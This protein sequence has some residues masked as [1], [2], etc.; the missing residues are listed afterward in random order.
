M[1]VLAGSGSLL[2]FHAEKDLPE[3]APEDE[4]LSPQRYDT[5]LAS[6]PPTSESAAIQL[7]SDLSAKYPDLRTHIVHLSAAD[8]LPILQ[9]AKNKGCLLT[10]ETC[11]H[12]LCLDSEDVSDGRCEFKCCPP[13][14]EAANREKLWTALLN[15]EVRHLC[16][17]SPLSP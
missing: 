1:S 7:V 11:F 16:A 9:Q 8:A 17:F 13:I 14:R 12:Y 6:R 2:M 3:P 4:H 5:F 15:D 10:A